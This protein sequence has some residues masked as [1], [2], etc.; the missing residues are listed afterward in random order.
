MEEDMPCPVADYSPSSE[1]LQ[2]PDLRGSV[3]KAF[4]STTF[5]NI[6]KKMQRGETLTG[7]QKCYD[8]EKSE[9]TSYGRRFTKSTK[10][11]PPN[12]LKGIHTAFSRQCN[13]ACRMCHSDYSTKW[14]GIERKLYPDKKTYP[15]PEIKLEEIISE[16][17]TYKNVDIWDIVG[18]EPFINDSFYRFLKKI[19]PWNLSEKTMELSTNCTFFPKPKYIDILL[20]FKTLDISLSIDGVGEL[21][22]Y[23][24]I[25]SKWPKVNKTVEAW[26]G[27]SL[28][29]PLN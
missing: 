21:G 2:D 10:H 7:C 15:S 12:V 17:E 20:Q 26:A 4:N 25:Y 8:E 27:V 28:K 1:E 29:K 16:E 13:L 6:R 14:N 9:N 24:R 22:E 18:G 23:I 11:F 19:K 3:E 5:K